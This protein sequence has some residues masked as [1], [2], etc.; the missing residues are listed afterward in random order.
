MNDAI[1]RKLATVLDTLPNGF[2]AKVA[3][4]PLTEDAWFEERGRNRGVDFSAYK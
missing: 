2:P 4:P 3:T 1:Y